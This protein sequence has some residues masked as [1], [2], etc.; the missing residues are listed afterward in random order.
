MTLT[1]SASSAPTAFVPIELAEYGSVVCDLARSTV[2]SIRTVAGTKVTL[3]PGEEPGTWS[4]QAGSHVGTIVVPG[5]RVLIKPK[6]ETANLFHLLGWST[7]IAFDPGQVFSYDT[8]RD[9]LATMGAFYAQTLERALVKGVVRRHV[10]TEDRLVA[11]RGRVDIP[12]QVRA[13]GIVTPIACR[14]DEYTADIPLNR[15]LREAAARM[16]RIPSLRP[17]VRGSLLRSMSRLEEASPLRPSDRTSPLAWTRL[18]QHARPAESLAR[19]ILDQLTFEQRTGHTAGAAFLVNMNTVFEQYLEKQLG[20][21]LR[22]SGYLVVGQDHHHLDVRRRVAVWPDIVV[23]RGK[24]V[25]F[26]ADA[27]YKL[28]PSGLGR[29]RDYYQLLAYCH[30]LGVPEGA[31]VY[32]FNDSDPPPGRCIDVVNNGPRLRTEM[33]SLTGTPAEIDAGVARLAQNIVQ[34][35]VAGRGIEPSG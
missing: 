7:G 8:Q 25:V 11:L 9:L 12:A 17:E 23:K 14:F 2:E 16:A 34:W 4:I 3:T 6:V 30:V 33:L 10:E 27:K 20:A 21:A 18:D 5:A 26:V 32:C 28:T 13:G 29:D 19:T 1:S 15:I 31:L 24:E 22:G 35:T